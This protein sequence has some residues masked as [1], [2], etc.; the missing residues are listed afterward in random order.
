MGY[1]VIMQKGSHLICVKTKEF[2]DDIEEALEWT[3]GGY[4]VILVTK[5]L[6]FIDLD[7]IDMEDKYE[8]LEESRIS[9]YNYFHEK[10]KKAIE[11]SFALLKRELLDKED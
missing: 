2:R 8:F 4:D 3:R 7:S 6:T 5:S 9:Q 10:D 11:K 1:Y